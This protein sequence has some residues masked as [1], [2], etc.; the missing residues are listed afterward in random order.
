MKLTTA[1][2]RLYNNLNEPNRYVFRN[3]KHSMLSPVF[4]IH[5]GVHIVLKYFHRSTVDAMIK[6][7]FLIL[8]DKPNTYKLR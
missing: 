6:M 3:E 4:H 1:Q 2:V 7:E 8:T 5:K